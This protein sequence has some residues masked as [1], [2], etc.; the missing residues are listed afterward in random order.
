ML[1]S[2][3]IHVTYNSNYMCKNRSH[4]P[5]SLRRRSAAARLLRLWF[6]VP[7][8]AE[9]FVC[10]ECYEFSG[11]SLCDQLITLPKESCRLWRVVVFNLESSRMKKGWPALGRSAKRKENTCI[12]KLFGWDDRHKISCRIYEEI[13]WNSVQRLLH[14]DWKNVL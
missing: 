13:L 12:I 10:C 14:S 9:V 6:R 4:W 8:G 5:R 3:K 1:V 7:P 2:F 11:R